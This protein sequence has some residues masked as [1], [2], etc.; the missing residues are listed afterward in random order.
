[1]LNLPIFPLLAVLGFITGI[2]EIECKS[3]ACNI[4]LRRVL[5]VVGLLTLLFSESVS[6]TYTQPQGVN[7]AGASQG[8]VQ[9]VYLL[10]VIM[11]EFS[12]VKHSVSREE[13]LEKIKELASYVEEAS[14]GMYK[15]EFYL[16]GKYY[17]LQKT[18]EFYDNDVWSLLKDSIEASDSEINFSQHAKVMIVHAGGNEAFTG[19]NRDIRSMYYNVH[20]G[21]PIKTNDGT[22]VSSAIIVSEFDPLG[23]LAH[24]FLHMLGAFDLYGRAGERERYVGYWDVMATGHRLG[25]ELVGNKLIGGKKPSHPSSW[26]KIKIGWLRDSDFAV[27]GPG[28]H[29]VELLPLESPTEG[30]HVIKVPIAHAKYYLIEVREKIGFDSYLPDEGFLVYICDDTATSVFKGLISV[31]DSNPSTKAL[32]PFKPGQ[33]LISKDGNIVIEFSKSDGKYIVT[34]DYRA[35][36]IIIKPIPP[37]EVGDKILLQA[38]VENAGNITASQ[39]EVSLFVDGVIHSKLNFDI[40]PPGGRMSV[41]AQLPKKPG[42]HTIL[43]EARIATDTLE[44]NE[45]DNRALINL[46]IPGK[47]EQKLQQWGSVPLPHSFTLVHLETADLNGDSVEE[48]IYYE[49]EGYDWRVYILSSD[50]SLIE[51]RTTKAV[52]LNDMDGDGVKEIFYIMSEEI[53]LISYKENGLSWKI[54]RVLPSEGLLISSDGQIKFGD[55]NNDGIMDIFI[56]YPSA[57]E[58]I[59]SKFGG[60]LSIY[61]PLNV[62]IINGK[63]GELLGNFTVTSKE[64][65]AFEFG[66]FCYVG[67]SSYGLLAVEDINGDSK[68]EIVIGLI[69]NDISENWYNE[70]AYVIYV[71]SIDGRLLWRKEIPIATG[72]WPIC[73]VKVGNFIGNDNKEIL[74]LR[75]YKAE[76]NSILLLDGKGDT[77]WSLDVNGGSFPGGSITT[78][79]G[80][81]VV[82]LTSEIILINS[83]TGGIKARFHVNNEPSEACTSVVVVPSIRRILVSTN[84]AFYL[85]DEDGRLITRKP[86]GTNSMFT[87]DAEGNLLIHVYKSKTVYRGSLQNG[88]IYEFFNTLTEPSEPSIIKIAN[89]DTDSDPEYVVLGTFLEVYNSDGSLMWTFGL[90]SW[91]EYG[92]PLDLDNDGIHDAVFVK[93]DFMQSFLYFRNGKIIYELEDCETDDLNGDGFKEV[94]CVSDRGLE[95]YDVD[96]NLIQSV[97]GADFRRISIG[98]TQYGKKIIAVSVGIFAIHMNM[99][100]QVRIYSAMGE[101]TKFI[102]FYWDPP[103]VQI[104]ESKI[105]GK[106][107]IL[108][109]AGWGRGEYHLEFYT[110][111]GILIFDRIVSEDVW[112]KCYDYGCR[113][114]LQDVDNDGKE[115]VILEK[116]VFSLGGKLLNINYRTTA[117]PKD[118]ILSMDIN[119]DGVVEV[120]KLP[121]WPWRS[122]II[123]SG[124]RTYTI[125]LDGFGKISGKIVAVKSGDR[126]LTLFIPTLTSKGYRLTPLRLFYVE[127]VSSYGNVKISGAPSQGYS[128]WYK[129][130]QKIVVEAEQVVDYGNGTRR[131]FISWNGDFYSTSPT[132]SINVDSPKRIVAKWKTQYLLTIISKHGNPQG[133]GW[134]DEGT[135]ATIT[136]STT[137]IKEVLYNKVF[138]G[139]RDQS[140]EIIATSPTYT[141]TVN[142]PVTLT[143]VWDQEP[144][145]IV[146]LAGPALVIATV[147]VL[148]TII[149]VKSRK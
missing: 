103:Y 58:E 92:K 37:C 14:Y 122:V 7:P 106:S 114:E 149:I 146:I 112:R 34:I 48:I 19:I 51:E 45:D 36:N 53:S 123:F 52:L 10:N 143:A 83:A 94:I 72:V 69:Y 86:F 107:Y 127:V 133:G 65:E 111:D 57:R 38:D 93:T 128:G 6:L 125:T 80:D 75:Y 62:C 134:Y 124:G 89:L 102:G 136:I 98:K 88:S 66:Y 20:C 13:I 90:E 33:K 141:F 113:A 108:V 25:V 110:A 64:E 2:Y 47:R 39:V 46:T 1:M 73:Y 28:R 147:I 23:V 21:A 142:Q 137:K 138:K 35:P 29:M 97:I 139:W 12:D 76:G 67:I 15:L 4:V 81:I 27:L 79:S 99:L 101:L 82:C 70:K 85:F 41:S 77:I 61:K 59:R 84:K 95:I 140:G 118:V 3:R 68:P 9:G 31:V 91:V 148:L 131:I 130:G 24:E 55:A 116:Y 17:T 54:Q 42:N 115:E 5:L 71:Y 96:G 126:E 109:V 8:Q 30:L 63:N 104:L 121:S 50:G 11:V 40:I 26:T 129:E 44:Y 56:L 119:S 144:N 105:T 22:L 117:E 32:D 60:T 100:P 49:R 74:L 120:V 145:E 43:W 132:V 16:T 18:M 87:F 78:S 135:E